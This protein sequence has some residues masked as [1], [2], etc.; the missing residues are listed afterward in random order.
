LALEGPE[1]FPYRVD[2]D[3]IF[4]PTALLWE[5]EGHDTAS[6][7]ARRGDRTDRSAW[8]SL[9]A[10]KGTDPAVFVVENFRNNVRR[11]KVICAGC[12][13]RQ[14]CLDYAVRN[15]ELMGVWGCTTTHERRVLRRASA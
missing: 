8:R 2:M 11:A 9:A 13:V 15:P 10:C 7:V 5:L 1:Q 6:G 4:D 3:G 12:S 14:D